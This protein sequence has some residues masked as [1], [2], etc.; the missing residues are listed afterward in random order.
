MMQA[1]H[2]PSTYVVFFTL[3]VFCKGGAAELIGTEEAEVTGDLSGYGGGEALE[4]A[5][6]PVILHD[7]FHHRPHCTADRGETI[8]SVNSPTHTHTHT[9]YNSITDR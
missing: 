6:G 9:R 4:E 7:G 3:H 8:G 2:C 5:P 1:E